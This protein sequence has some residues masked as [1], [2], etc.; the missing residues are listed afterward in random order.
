M[1]IGRSENEEEKLY[2]NW[3]YKGEN[4]RGSGPAC[5]SEPLAPQNQATIAIWICH[6]NQTALEAAMRWRWEY[7]PEYDD[8]YDEEDE[9]EYEA[10]DEDGEFDDPADDYIMTERELRGDL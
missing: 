4:P 2:Q 1:D 5:E 9:E 3:N 7:P 10:P 8:V 6:S